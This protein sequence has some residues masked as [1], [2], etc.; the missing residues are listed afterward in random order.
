MKIL[1]DICDSRDGVQGIKGDVGP[2]GEKDQ[3]KTGAKR[4]PAGGIVYVR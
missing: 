3:G 4:E 2:H 1:P